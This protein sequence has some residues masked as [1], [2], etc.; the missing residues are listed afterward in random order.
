MAPAAVTKVVNAD[1]EELER[2]KA[3]ALSRNMCLRG[4]FGVPFLWLV[5]FWYFYP[6]IRKKDS[7]PHVKRNAALSL[8]AFAAFL[9]ALVAWMLVYHI[10]GEA[11]LGEKYEELNISNVDLDA[12]LQAS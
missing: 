8:S 3:R 1:G 11:L 2:D 10:G 5:H 12:L 6:E 4:L 9:A 7:D